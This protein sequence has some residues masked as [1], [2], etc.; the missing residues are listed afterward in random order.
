MHGNTETSFTLLRNEKVLM[1]T[2]SVVFVCDSV[3]VCV[4]VV[5]VFVE[6]ML[7]YLEGAHEHLRGW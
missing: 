5:G 7:S 4:H 3:C 1:P 6:E 2:V